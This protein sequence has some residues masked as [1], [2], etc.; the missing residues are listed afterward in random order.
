MRDRIVAHAVLDAAEPISRSKESAMPNVSNTIWI[1]V[2]ILA[3]IALIVFIV[4]N[5]SIN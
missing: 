1:V 3:I 2:G 4:Q 5:T